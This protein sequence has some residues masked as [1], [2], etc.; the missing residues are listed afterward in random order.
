[1][2]PEKGGTGKEQNES[3]GNRTAWK[4]SVADLPRSNRKGL[5]MQLDFNG[6]RFVSGRDELNYQAV[7]DDFP[8]AKTIRIITFNIS[9][10]TYFQITTISI[11]KFC[12]GNISQQTIILF[13]EIFK[14]IQSILTFLYGYYFSIICGSHRANILALFSTADSALEQI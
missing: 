1:M 8:R 10:I 6:G 2:E 11:W 5:E 7:L 13:I 3:A 12:Y 9:N 14:H 4:P